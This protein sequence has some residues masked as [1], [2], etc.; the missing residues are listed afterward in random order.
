LKTFEGLG[1]HPNKY[2]WYECKRRSTSRDKRC[3][4]EKKAKEKEREEEEERR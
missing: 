4:T 2:E 3:F 1:G